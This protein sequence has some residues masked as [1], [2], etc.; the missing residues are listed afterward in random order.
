MSY[1]K[2]QTKDFTVRGSGSTEI[3]S[4]GLLAE[5]VEVRISGAG[6]ADVFA[7]VK[8]DV[9]VSGAGSI[10]YKGNPTVNQKMSGAGNIKKVD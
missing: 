8:L 7:S 1:L 3:K 5:N 9:T 6:D 10:R 4:F 2:S